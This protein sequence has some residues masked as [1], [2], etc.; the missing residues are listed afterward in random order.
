MQ[1]PNAAVTSHALH[2]CPRPS[3]STLLLST[4]PP[5]ALGRLLERVVDEMTDDIHY[6]EVDI[7]E[8]PDVAQNA[9]ITGTPTVQVKIRE[10]LK[11]RLFE[12]CSRKQK[13]Y[14]VLRCWTGKS[15]LGH[16]FLLA[17][18]RRCPTE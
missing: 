7:T 4:P 8:S 1:M 14:G 17:C 3:D 10:R 9:G 13:G 15:A 18:R 11:K 2:Y 12:T 5:Q 6:V 16:T